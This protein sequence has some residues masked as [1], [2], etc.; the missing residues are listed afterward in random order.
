LQPVKSVAALVEHVDRAL[1]VAK[2]GGGDP[3]L[4]AAGDTEWP[5][6]AGHRAKGAHGDPGVVAS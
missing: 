2:A 5:H 1:Y 4:V 3:M 6:D